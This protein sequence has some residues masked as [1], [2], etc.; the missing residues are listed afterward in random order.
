MIAE[1]ADIGDTDKINSA[2]MGGVIGGVSA[3]VVS[4]LVIIMIVK[5]KQMKNKLKIA[6]MKPSKVTGNVCV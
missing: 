6:A 3:L 2:V 4:I 5:K 1:I